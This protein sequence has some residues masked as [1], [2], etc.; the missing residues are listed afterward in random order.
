MMSLQSDYC[1]SL[2]GDRNA[3]PASQ[4]RLR[5]LCV[6]DV[7]PD[8]DAGAS[9]TQVRLVQWLRALGHDVDAVWSDDLP[10]RIRHPNSHDV[11][12]KPYN[13]RNLIRRRW[14]SNCYDVVC[15]NQPMGYL[16]ARDH[17]RWHRP[18]IFVRWSMGLEYGLE[19]ALREWLPKWGLR[20][21]S[22]WKELPG[23]MLDWI[24]YRQ[25][26]SIARH[27]DAHIVLCEKDREILTGHFGIPQE[28]TAN[29]LQAPLESFQETESLPMTP[30]RQAKILTA[31]QFIPYKGY[32]HTA[33][34]VNAILNADPAVRFTWAGCSNS[35]PVIRTLIEPQLQDRISVPGKLGDIEFR[36]MFD[37]HGI[38]LFPSINEGF[39]KTFLE[40]MARGLCVVATNVGG[41]RDVIRQGENGFLVE[42]GDVPSMVRHIQSLQR[43]FQLARR[44]SEAAVESSRK[45]T[46][47]RVAQE[48][49]EF[50]RKVL[51]TKRNPAAAK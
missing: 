30:A 6:A 18:G 25:E 16:A 23:R 24:V 21:R 12:E 22:P 51:H 17:R 40:A 5:F 44:I 26:V 38:F 14:R 49:A 36:Q 37:D 39:G 34:A 7:P 2:N 35:L 9:G 31:G 3:I 8:P 15:V 47:K 4:A 42:P 11:F 1:A 45:Y 43:D 20:K 48:T 32:P 29:V 46:W 33:M 41:M 28:L 27:A 50:C 13:Y 19:Q 10:H